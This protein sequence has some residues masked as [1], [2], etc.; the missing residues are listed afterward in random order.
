MLNSSQRAYLRG[1][2]NELNA[3]FQIGKGG[4]SDEM[5]RQISNALEAREL[6]QIKVLQNSD[7]SAA[8]AA[9]TIAEATHADVV[10]SVGSK[11]VL[12]RES[13]NNKRIFL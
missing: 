11:F 2:S 12:Y 13:E 4:I 9:K 7:Y 10:V 1:L 8:E 6:V 3:I 5:C